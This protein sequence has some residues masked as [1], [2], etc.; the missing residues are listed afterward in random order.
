METGEDAF[1][2]LWP[3]RSSNIECSILTLNDHRDAFSQ[4]GCSWI[5]GPAVLLRDGFKLLM[6]KRINGV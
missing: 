1:P 6:A 3:M 5:R 2:V 4:F